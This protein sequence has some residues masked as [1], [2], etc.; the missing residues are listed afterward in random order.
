[1]RRKSVLNLASNFPALGCVPI[2][3]LLCLQMQELHSQL[4]S[5]MMGPLQVPKLSA[6]NFKPQTKTWFV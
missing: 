5:F 2:K 6:S 4:E 1:M 3:D